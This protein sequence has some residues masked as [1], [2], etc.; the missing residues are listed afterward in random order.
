MLYFYGVLIFLCII[1]IIGLFAHNSHNQPII[2]ALSSISSSLKDSLDKLKDQLKL[3]QGQFNLHKKDIDQW[4]LN[5]TN[6]IKRLGKTEQLI[7]ANSRECN[8]RFTDLIQKLT[9]LE[10][11]LDAKNGN[12]Q[13]IA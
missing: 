9:Q 13:S 10:A 1:F 3:L 5:Q 11:K 2:S 7:N 12:G 6:V 4:E 8:Q